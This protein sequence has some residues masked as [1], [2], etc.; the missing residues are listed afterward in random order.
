VATSVM[1]ACATPLGDKIKS[2][3]ASSKEVERN[4]GW[5]RGFTKK[6]PPNI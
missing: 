6:C 4:K 1:G 3:I 5:E 2:S